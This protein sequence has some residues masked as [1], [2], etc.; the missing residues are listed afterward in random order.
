M[1]FTI[2]LSFPNYNYYNLYVI[3]DIDLWVTIIYSKEYEDTNINQL[4]FHGIKHNY[5]SKIAVTY[6]KATRHG[7]CINEL[8]K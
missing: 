1:S 6:K 2:P 8:F 7:K 5:F 3:N 4:N